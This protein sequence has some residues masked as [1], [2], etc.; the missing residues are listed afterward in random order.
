MDHMNKGGILWVNGFSE[1][2]DDHPNITELDILKEDDFIDLESYQ[3][4]HKKIY[5]VNQRKFIR[6]I[7][8]K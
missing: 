7:W 4:E 2:S 6:G 3:L 1:V 8:R 5:E